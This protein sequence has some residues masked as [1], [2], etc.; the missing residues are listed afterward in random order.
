LLL[1][2]SV[3]VCFGGGTNLW[4]APLLISPIATLLVVILPRV[5]YGS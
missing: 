3:L 1:I 4:L 5:P 2:V